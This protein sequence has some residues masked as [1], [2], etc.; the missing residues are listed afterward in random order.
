MEKERGE[1]YCVQLWQNNVGLTFFL[2]LMELLPRTM[3]LHPVSA[4]SCLAVSPRGPRILPTKLYCRY[5][6]RNKTGEAMVNTQFERLRHLHFL[7][8]SIWNQTTVQKGLLSDWN[9]SITRADLQFHLE[10][11]AHAHKHRHTQ[12]TLCSSCSSYVA[13]ESKWISSVL[14]ESK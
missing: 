5:R 4:S 12:S 14:C 3:I 10:L 13:E 2:S 6:G 9:P 11:E 8:V 7:D 1:I